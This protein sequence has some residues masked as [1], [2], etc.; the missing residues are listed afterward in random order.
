MCA[1]VPIIIAFSW[2]L[3]HY[4]NI[5]C[6][7]LNC[8]R[9]LRYNM[10]LPWQLTIVALRMNSG[11]RLPIDGEGIGSCVCLAWRDKP[12][13]YLLQEKYDLLSL[14]KM[15]CSVHE[16]HTSCFMRLTEFRNL[17]ETNLYPRA[18]SMWFVLNGPFILKHLF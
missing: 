16:M 8:S 3:L 4:S 18:W 6:G 9:S 7:N 2:A 5:S 1:Q 10:R 17:N 13:L 15:I 11:I 12:L 14:P